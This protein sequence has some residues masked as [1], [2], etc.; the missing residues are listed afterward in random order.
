[1]G[2]SASHPRSPSTPHHPL[3]G[4]QHPV[5]LPGTGSKV[6]WCCHSRRP[7]GEGQTGEAGTVTGSPLVNNDGPCSLFKALNRGW[8]LSSPEFGAWG[9]LALV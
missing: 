3:P 9:V 4:P 1:M 7:L 6:G 8:Y 5:Y 2:C